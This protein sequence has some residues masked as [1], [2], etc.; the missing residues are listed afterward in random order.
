MLLF[1]I[2][3]IIINRQ[4]EVED[5]TIVD[6]SDAGIIYSINVIFLF[7]K[8]YL[9]PETSSECTYFGLLWPAAKKG[10]DTCSRRYG[11]FPSWSDLLLVLYIDYLVIEYDV[12]YL[13]THLTG[14][15]VLNKVDFASCFVNIVKIYP[16]DLLPVKEISDMIQM[17]RRPRSLS[18]HG[19]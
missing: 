8:K 19:I 2:S 11:V 14:K 4:A 3:I 5:D 16:P 6:F 12:Q 1:I 10:S 7:T 18:L 13:K 15:V 17:N 9:F